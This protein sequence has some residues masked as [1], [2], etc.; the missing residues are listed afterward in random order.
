MRTSGKDSWRR[1][2]C[3]HDS[4]DGRDSGRDAGETGKGRKIIGLETGG[5]GM[6]LPPLILQA[7]MSLK[8]IHIQ[9]GKVSY[10]EWAL[11]H[12]VLVQK[13]GLPFFWAQRGLYQGVRLREQSAGWS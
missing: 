11:P 10:S 12:D 9:T 5:A 13:K 6:V 3:G 7:R 8:G 2:P 4:Q 1:G